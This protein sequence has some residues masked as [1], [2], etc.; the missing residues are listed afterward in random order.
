MHRLLACL[1]ALLL[2]A[3]AVGNQHDYT[4]AMP[5]LTAQGSSSV[6]VAVQDQRP[7]ILD[8][9]KKENFCGLYRGGFGNPFDITT[10]SK[11]PLSMDFR[12]TIVAALKS[13][14]FSADPVE[15]ALASSDQEAKQALLAAAKDR[16]LLLVI[17]EWKSDTYF[18]TGLLYDVTLTV[19]DRSGGILAESKIG[20]AKDNL[21]PAALPRDARIAVAKAYQTKL[22]AL[23][24]DPKVVEALQQ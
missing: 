7:Y 12:N 19:L 9:D 17:K 24:N 2:S 21:G 16:A 3:C 5:Q 8:H 15:T 4:T 10:L 22:E 20:A 11:N 13:K 1:A 18:N 23:L 6:V 14:G